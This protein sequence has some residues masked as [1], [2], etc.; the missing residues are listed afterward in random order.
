V[1]FFAT[2]NGTI[3]GSAI[4]LGQATSNTLTLAAGQT[5][6][7]IGVNLTMPDPLITTTYKI[8]ARIT[9]TGFN[10]AFTEDNVTGVLATVTVLP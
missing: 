9:S 5:S 8:V 1:T 6:N 2:A 4:Q 7:N 10:D 3:D